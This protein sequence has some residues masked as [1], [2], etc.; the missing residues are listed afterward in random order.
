MKKLF[1]VLLLMLLMFSGKSFSQDSN[2]AKPE[3][4]HPA[5]LV[6]DIQNAFL[7]HMDQT[8]VEKTM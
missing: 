3:R 8:E 4:L 1:S 2:T 5:L 6:I 7:P